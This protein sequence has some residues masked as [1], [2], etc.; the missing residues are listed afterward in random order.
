MHKECISPGNISTN[1]TVCYMPKIN[2]LVSDFKILN[3]QE[4]MSP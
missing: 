3:Q 2:C 4:L 1:C